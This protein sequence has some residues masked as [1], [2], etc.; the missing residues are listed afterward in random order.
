MKSD[1]TFLESDKYTT[2]R[3]KWSKTDINYIRVFIM[4]IAIKDFT[5]LVIAL[6]SLFIYNRQPPHA[7]LFSFN[8]VS[9]S[10]Q[11]VINKLQ[12]RLLSNG[13]LTISFS[14]HSFRRSIAQ[15]VLDNDIL[16]KDI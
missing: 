6:H 5:Y 4:L 12:A 3:L 9:F 14:D 16:G 8:N 15:Y 11:Y 10:R 13:V 7:A 1:V 2:L